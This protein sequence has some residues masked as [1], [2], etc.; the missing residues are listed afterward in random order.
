MK[1]DF[2]KELVVG[3]CSTKYVFFEDFAKFTGKRLCLSYFF[4][5]YADLRQA[6]KSSNS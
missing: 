4:N 3:R 2:E 5:K 6:I 1:N